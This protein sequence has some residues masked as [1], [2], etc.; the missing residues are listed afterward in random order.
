MAQHHHQ[1]AFRAAFVR[2]E[3]AA[4]RGAN[5]EHREKI[6]RDARNRHL[7]RLARAGEIQV[8]VG[9]GGNLEGAGAVPQ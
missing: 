4:Q 3:G 6:R 2:G 1:M 9:P 5:A 7:H 8:V